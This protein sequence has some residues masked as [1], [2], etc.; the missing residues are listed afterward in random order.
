[1]TKG[2]IAAVVHEKLDG[3]FSKKEVADLVDAVLDTVKDALQGGEAV[4][5]SGFGKFVVRQKR[6]RVGR[7]PRTGEMLSI[8]SRRVLTFKPSVMLKAALNAQGE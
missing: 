6:D 3:A 4:K 2:D 7:N 1:M 8:A 5:V